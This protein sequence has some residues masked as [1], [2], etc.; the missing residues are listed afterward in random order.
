LKQK[1]LDRSAIE[2]RRFNQPKT[3][4]GIE[5][6]FNVDPTFLQIGFNQSKTL[7]G[8]ETRTNDSIALATAYRFNQP[9][10]LSGIETCGFVIVAKVIDPASTN[11]KPFQG[12][13]QQ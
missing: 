9:K 3:L 11:P 2:R 7:S 10:T 8:I 6:V 5:T 4:S 12:L 1:L 13:K